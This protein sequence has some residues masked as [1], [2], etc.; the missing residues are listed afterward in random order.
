MV[1]TRKR[2]AAAVEPEK[3][4]TPDAVKDQATPE[5]KAP[6]ATKGR[7]KAKTQPKGGRKKKQEEPVVVDQEADDVHVEDDTGEVEITHPEA[8]NTGEKKG[9]ENSNGDQAKEEEQEELLPVTDDTP[10]EQK[11][12]EAEQNTPGQGDQN[13]HH[14]SSSEE[15]GVVR[16]EVA[17]PTSYENTKDTSAGGEGDEDELVRIEKELETNRRYNQIDAGTKKRL[18]VILEYTKLQPKDVDSRV[19]QQLSKMPKKE[20]LEAMK[21]LD[22]S[23]RTSK[24]RNLSAYLSSMLRRLSKSGGEAAAPSQKAHGTARDIAPRARAI[25]QDLEDSHLVRQGELDGKA[26]GTLAEKPEELQI[27]TMEMFSSR[28]LRSVRNMTGTCFL[29]ERILTYL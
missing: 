16:G 19:L 14:P 3:Q 7:K 21:M 5:Q 25:L 4:E 6:V 9:E 18:A 22:Q 28:N 13:D 15:E 24:I 20:S 23:V 26:L 27:L 2:S 29:C 11:T 17:P 1:T 10:K 12:D 8:E